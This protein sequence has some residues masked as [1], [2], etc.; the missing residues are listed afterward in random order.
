MPVYMLPL[1]MLYSPVSGDNEPQELI[2][3]RMSDGSFVVVGCN[4][5]EDA[6]ESMV[7]QA[8]IELGKAFFLSWGRNLQEALEYFYRHC[9]FSQHG[10]PNNRAVWVDSQEFILEI[11][12][13][14]WLEV[15]PDGDACHLGDSHQGCFLGKD[16]SIP[17]GCPLSDWI[18]KLRQ[19][20]RP[21]F[22]MSCGFC[23]VRANALTDGPRRPSRRRK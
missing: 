21:P 14:R 3:C 20:K 1:A 17:Q 7:N 13:C 15:T 18:E 19:T 6:T 10:A 16:L 12:D 8:D 5:P 2:G 9:H 4:H 11:P 23:L 22:V